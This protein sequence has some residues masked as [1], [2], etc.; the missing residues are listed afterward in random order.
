MNISE[1]SFSKLSFNQQTVIKAL[2]EKPEGM[3]SRAITHK[4][5]VSN[6]SSIVNMNLLNVLAEE[7][8]ELCT[9][10]ESRQWRWSLRPL[11]RTN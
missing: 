5:G 7:G 4:T 10:R 3:L 11:I 9:E 6:K 2:A 8:L 1:K